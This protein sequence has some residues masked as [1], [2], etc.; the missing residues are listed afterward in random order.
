M[1]LSIGLSFLFLIVQ[2]SEC[3]LEPVQ[4]REST[5]LID[6]DIIKSNYEKLSTKLPLKHPVMAIVKANAYGVGA[7]AVSQ[8]FLELGATYLGVAFVDEGVYLRR[9]GIEAPIVVLGYTSDNGRGIDLAIRY[10][11]TLNVS[12]KR[13]LDAVQ[14]RAMD[15]NSEPVKIHIKVN[16]G[17]NRL[18]LEPDEL[19]PF[20]KLIKRQFYSKVSIEG[21]FS[22]FAT[23]RA[24]PLTTRAEKYARN[25]LNIFKRVVKEARKVT[26]IPIAH[27]ANSGGINLF[28]HE[29]SLDMVRPG[30][31]ILGFSPF[32]QYAISLTSIISAIRRPAKGQHLGYE[33]NAT[34]DGNQM[35][36]TVPLGYAD[37]L[38]LE[39]GNG[40]SEVL[41]KGIRVPV[42]SG[43][44]MDQ[45][46]IDVSRV[47]PVTVGDEVVVLGRQRG[48]EITI[49]EYT[50]RCG[51]TDTS[52]TTQLNRRL[53]R[54]YSRNGKAAYYENNLLS[55][56][57][58]VK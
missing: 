30:I 33:Q 1:L 54:V 40:M 50:K 27:I 32:G 5:L 17:L 58:V 36:A 8:T 53:P 19:V 6:L 43:I 46:L 20:L 10:N 51:G 28:G 34:A 3:S 44:M 26:D 7:V 12:S 39:C 45:M 38:R 13:I 11:L 25:Q 4:G 14:N 15:L 24:I 42:V 56:D 16:S 49:D 35:I 41:I 9:H 22:H 52:F 47:Y 55:Y 18:G 57:V 2:Y 29:A 21:V 37:G 23:L 48:A 31:S